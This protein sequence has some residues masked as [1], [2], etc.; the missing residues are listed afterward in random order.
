MH[1]GKPLTFAEIAAPFRCTIFDSAQATFLPEAFMGLKEVNR[2]C[3]VM[4]SVY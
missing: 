2:R 1:F 4:Q 3:R